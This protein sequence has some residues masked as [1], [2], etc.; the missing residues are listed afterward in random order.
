M[1]FCCDEQFGGI[2]SIDFYLLSET[3]NWPIVVTDAN[4]AQITFTPEPVEVD[5]TIVPDSINI[6]DKPSLSAQGKIWPIEIEYTF[7]SRGKGIEQLLEQYCGQPGVAKA[8]FNDG[9]CKLY[10]TNLQPLYLDWSNQYGEKIDDKH[11]VPIKIKGDMSQRP[12]Y[13]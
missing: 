11:G 8:N 12:V 4:A 3:G 10:G 2:A 1:N 7:M 5:G 13:I 9:S 6:D